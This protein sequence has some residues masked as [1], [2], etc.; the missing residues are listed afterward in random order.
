MSVSNYQEVGIDARVVGEAI[1]D[2]QP[3]FMASIN[4]FKHA[5]HVTNLTTLS[6]L[7]NK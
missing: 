2:Q 3:C 6:K 1:L 4:E 7:P 5:I